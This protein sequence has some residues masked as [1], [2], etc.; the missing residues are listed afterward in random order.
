[1]K[2]FF[3][4]FTLFLGEPRGIFPEKMSLDLETLAPQR[5]LCTRAIA[6]CTKP[7]TQSRASAIVCELLVYTTG[8]KC[9]FIFSQFFHWGYYKYE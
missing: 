5:Q 4:D 1:M 3:F 2:R 6:S 7:N 8:K 9:Y